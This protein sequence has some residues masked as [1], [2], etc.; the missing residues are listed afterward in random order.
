MPD[1]VN[2]VLAFTP[3]SLTVTST[4]VITSAPIEISWAENGV[5]IAWNVVFVNPVSPTPLA[6]L[7]LEESDEFAGPW[8]TIEDDR[9]IVSDFFIKEFGFD[10]LLTLKAAA[11][12]F[13]A[14]PFFQLR[15]LK[16]FFRV[17][18]DSFIGGGQIMV[19]SV[20]VFAHAELSPVIKNNIPFA[21]SGPT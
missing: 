13:S 1:K 17:R 10:K 21:V 14:V 4:G 18:V 6:E 7:L 11:L 16:R 15:D 8:S 2:N 20:N 5:T 12:N 3:L 9:L 19:V